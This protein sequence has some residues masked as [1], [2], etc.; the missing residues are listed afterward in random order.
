MKIRKRMWK[1]VLPV[2]LSADDDTFIKL[3]FLL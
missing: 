3:L 1:R 2:T